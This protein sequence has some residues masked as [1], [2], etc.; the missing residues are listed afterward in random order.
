LR[1]AGVELDNQGRSSIYINP[2]AIPQSPDFKPND[3]EFPNE[4]RYLLV[5]RE[6]SLGSVPADQGAVG[7]VIAIDGEAVT[8]RWPNNQTSIHLRRDL[9]PAEPPSE[10]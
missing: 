9:K 10:P 8:V 3:P 4:G 2:T 1:R 7:E 6:L 5:V